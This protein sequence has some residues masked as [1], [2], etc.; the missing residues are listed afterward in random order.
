MDLNQLQ[1]YI[2]ELEAQI[3][4]E[5]LQENQQ[6]PSEVVENE[7]EPADQPVAE[8]NAPPTI[9]ISHLF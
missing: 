4:K 5:E 6:N 1:F 8:A 9:D 7:L 3:I 2:N